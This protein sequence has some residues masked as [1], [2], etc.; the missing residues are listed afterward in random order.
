MQAQGDVRD[1][2]LQLLPMVR[3]VANTMLY[4]VDGGVNVFVKMSSA[5]ISVGFAL[6][7]G[8]GIDRSN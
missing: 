2:K 8:I 5:V 1:G 7:D 4:V 6:N 3:S